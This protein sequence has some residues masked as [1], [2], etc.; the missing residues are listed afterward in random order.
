MWTSTV[1]RASHQFMPRTHIW[2]GM[3]CSSSV[4]FFFFACSQETQREPMCLQGGPRRETRMRWERRREQRLSGTLKIVPVKGKS[5]RR[6]PWLV[7]PEKAE[8][9]MKTSVKVVYMKRSQEGGKTKRLR[10]RRRKTQMSH[11]H[12]DQSTGVSSLCVWAQSCPYCLWPHGMQPIRL[13]C[14]RGSPGKN[15]GVDCHFFLQ[16][17]LPT[18]E[19]NLHLL[20][21]LHCRRIHYLLSYQ[22]I[23]SSLLLLLSH[24]SRV[25][26]CATP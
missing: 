12:F 19:S 8:P 2:G 7:L 26:L 15:T 13:L 10:Q 6:D 11:C 23:V 5:S 14:P 18:Q 22:G 16:G 25:Q 1:S 4:P 17:I 9:E 3:F 24:F 20:R 21:L